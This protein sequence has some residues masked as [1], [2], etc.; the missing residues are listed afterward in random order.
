MKLIDIPASAFSD[1]HTEL[2]RKRLLVNQY[3]DVAGVG[4]SQTFGVVNRR[5]LPPDYCRL[6][7]ARPY[8]YKLL[9][10]FGAA[11]VPFSFSSITVNDSYRAA[12]HRDKGNT[13]DSLV[14]AFGE[15]TGGELRLHE[16]DD[17]GVYDIK[18][19]GI[20]ADFKATLHSV[21]PFEGRRFSLV[22]YNIQHKRLVPLPPPSIVQNED[23]KYVFKRGDVVCKGLPHP[24]QGTKHKKQSHPD[25]S[26]V[27]ESVSFEVT[28]D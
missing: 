28:F 2:L 20:V 6:C 22:F 7:W 17:A 15:Y 14:V 13:G 18:H 25:E 11:Y 5:C 10:E 3:R 19:R 23:G 27:R 12:P 21:E 16:G 9:L 4:R 1:I 26:D 8:L 24:L